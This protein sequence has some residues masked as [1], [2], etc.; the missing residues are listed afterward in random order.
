MSFHNLRQAA[1][2]LLL[3]H[4][5]N[6]VLHWVDVYLTHIQPGRVDLTQVDVRWSQVA[7]IGDTV[8]QAAYPKGF[9]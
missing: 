4:E 2:C 5:T 8:I 6:T 9:F 1:D 3:Q 7:A